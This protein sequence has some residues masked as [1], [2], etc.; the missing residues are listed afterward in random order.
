[1]AVTANVDK[2]VYML[3]RLLPMVSPRDSV[4]LIHIV[5][6]SMEDIIA[7]E[8]EDVEQVNTQFSAAEQGL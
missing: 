3:D 8:T 1:M 2:V 6:E 5:D 7:D 4:V